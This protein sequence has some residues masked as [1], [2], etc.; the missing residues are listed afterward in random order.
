NAGEFRHA[1]RNKETFKSEYAAFPQRTNLS[2]ITRHHAAPETNVDPQLACGRS[3]FLAIS[4]DG[5]RRGN[6]VERHFKESCHS[7]RRGRAGCRREPLPIGASRLVDV[8]VRIHDP[9]HDYK[10]SCVV[11]GNAN[12]KLAA[13]SNRENLAP[14][15]VD[16]RGTF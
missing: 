4:S 6:T 12:R 1:A 9:G 15:H 16:R 10:V 11:D 3:Q 13:V 2:V 7:P 14:A 8:Y 5:G